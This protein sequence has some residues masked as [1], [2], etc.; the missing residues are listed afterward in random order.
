MTGSVVAFFTC[1]VL[2]VAPT[3]PA[4]AL[5]AEGTVEAVDT[6]SRLLTL[7]DGSCFGLPQGFDLEGVGAGTLARLV[8]EP[9]TA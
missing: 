6:A 8:Y 1:S 5:E 3:I 7:S 2:V 9:T 4:H